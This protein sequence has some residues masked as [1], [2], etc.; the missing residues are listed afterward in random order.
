MNIYVHM[1]SQMQEW[2]DIKAAVVQEELARERLIRRLERKHAG[3]GGGGGGSGGGRGV[4]AEGRKER[5]RE[6]G[7]GEGVD[8]GNRED[9]GSWWR[10]LVS[11]ETYTSVK[12]DLH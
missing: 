6:G 8:V 4:E 11:K 1:C 2:R 12:R 3:G 10:A 7:T 9:V 5:E